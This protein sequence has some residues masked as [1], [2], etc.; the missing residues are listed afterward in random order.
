MIYRQSF[1]QRLRFIGIG[2]LAI[3]LLGIT[4]PAVADPCEVVDDGTGTIALPPAGCDYLSPDEVHEIIDGLPPDTTIEL[5][6]IHKD[7]I[8]SDR[9]ECSQLLPPGECEVP[10]PDV[11]GGH[12]DCFESTLELS[13]T[14]TGAL[15]TFSRTLFVPMQTEVHTGPRTPGDGVQDFDTEMVQLQGELFGD[16]DFCTLRVSAGSNNGLPSPGHT[17]LTRLGPPGSD[18][19]VDSFFDITYQIEYV[20]CP[21]SQ[22]EGFGA[23]TQG[24]IRMSAGEPAVPEG[25]DHFQCWQVKDLKNPPFDKRVVSLADQFVT[26]DVEVKKLFVVCAPA[27]KDGSGILDSETH[28]CCYKTKGP[29]LDPTAGVA[30]I[31]QFGR[32]EAAVKKAKFLCQPCSKTL[33][34][35]P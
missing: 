34:E 1:G 14:G 13:L 24:T 21:G 23:T 10:D 12:V 17:T 6:A 33:I 31:D 7:F 8:C 18:F 19:A 5:A 32:H 29:K 11:P 3:G 16:P 35:L 15:E 27:D 26:S 30:V 20:G 22:L 2:L 25:L 4:S 9:A 28:Q